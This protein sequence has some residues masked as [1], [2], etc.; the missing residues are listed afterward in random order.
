VNRARARLLKI[1]D[2]EDASDVMA[3][4]AVQAMGSA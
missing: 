2:A 3:L 1:M 4:E